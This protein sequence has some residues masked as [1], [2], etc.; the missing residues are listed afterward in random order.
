MATY[1]G[2]EAPDYEGF[3]EHL[4]K[5][6]TPG[7]ENIEEELNLWPE[8]GTDR[9]RRPGEKG[10][11]KEQHIAGSPTPRIRGNL[12]EPVGVDRD[13]SQGR[14][15]PQRPMEWYERSQPKGTSAAG[16]YAPNPW[17]PYPKPPPG[18]SAGRGMTDAELAELHRTN[19]EYYGDPKEQFQHGGMVEQPSCKH[20]SSTVVTCRSK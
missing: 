5:Q 14:E 16:N 4:G 3:Q 1:R 19:P 20:G 12:P 7:L 17:G 18:I 9:T 13:E 11:M 10:Y 8:A 15:L 6:G 2:G